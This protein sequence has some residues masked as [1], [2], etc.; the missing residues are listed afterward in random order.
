VHRVFLSTSLFAIFLKLIHCSGS[1]TFRYGSG[2]CS[3]RLWPSRYQQK[4]KYFFVSF[5]LLLFKY[6]ITSFFTDE[7]LQ[8]SHSAVGIKGFLTN[9]CLMMVGSGS[10][11][12]TNGSWR[13]KN[14]WIRLQIGSA[15]LISRD[16]DCT[17]VGHTGSV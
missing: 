7:K 6:T 11:H 14:L 5:C 2:S 13:A 16:D 3:F 15:E 4:K 10:V 17:Y 1:V 12:L 8:I 9:F